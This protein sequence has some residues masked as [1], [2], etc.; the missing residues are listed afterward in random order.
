MAGRADAR[1]RSPRVFLNYH[2]QHFGIMP[3]AA[4]DQIPNPLWTSLWSSERH[5]PLR[6]LDR[7]DIS[8]KLTIIKGKP[9]CLF[10]RLCGIFMVETFNGAFAT[11]CPEHPLSYYRRKCLTRLWQ[12]KF[13]YAVHGE[14]DAANEGRFQGTRRLAAKA[15]PALLALPAAPPPVPVPA[16]KAK[17]AP[18]LE[19]KPRALL[20]LPAPAPKPPAKPV[21]F[22]M[23]LR[24]GRPDVLYDLEA[25]VL[26]LQPPQLPAKAKPVPFPMQHQIVPKMMFE[27]L[28]QLHRQMAQDPLPD[29][30]SDS[31]AQATN[32]PSFFSDSSSS[33]GNAGSA[34]QDGRH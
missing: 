33:R 14:T 30:D 16:P 23:Q 5:E 1:S 29:I 27:V 17:A 25:M 9:G 7:I 34:S 4:D 3:M 28:P 19:A 18:A 11:V 12:G 21:P 6:N 2:S 24:V 13:P 15:A 26:P 10:C 20:A 22:P 32:S 31:D 8:H